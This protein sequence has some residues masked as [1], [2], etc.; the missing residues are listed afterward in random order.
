LILKDDPQRF[1]EAV[2]RLVH[3]IDAV[4]G[5]KDYASVVTAAIQHNKVTTKAVA[6]WLG[7]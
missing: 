6:T 4:Y 7:L 1:A 2:K 3:E 5:E